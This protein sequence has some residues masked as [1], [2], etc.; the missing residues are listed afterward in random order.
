[1]NRKPLMRVAAFLAFAALVLTSLVAYAGKDNTTSSCD[2][3]VQNGAN[4]C[5]MWTT[6]ISAAPITVDGTNT[7]TEWT[8]VPSK[9]PSGTL[10]GAHTIQVRHVK[11]PTGDSLSFLITI[12]DASF[13][14]DDRVDLHFDPLHND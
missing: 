10:S 14:A 9:T 2:N 5:C 7:G 3:L 4:D 11:T 1:M 6:P 8:G 13:S 12:F